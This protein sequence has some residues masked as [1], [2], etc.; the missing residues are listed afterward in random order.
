[1]EALDDGIHRASDGWQRRGH[2]ELHLRGGLM[3]C[4]HQRRGVELVQLSSRT[5]F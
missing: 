3:K 5:P 2:C 1:L 4:E